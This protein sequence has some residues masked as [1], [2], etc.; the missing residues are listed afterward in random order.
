MYQLVNTF[1]NLYFQSV[2]ISY[3]PVV[4]DYIDIPV[5]KDHI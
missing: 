2:E 5:N 3:F 1:M 4:T